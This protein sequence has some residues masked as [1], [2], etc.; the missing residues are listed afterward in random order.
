MPFESFGF[1]IPFPQGVDLAK[2]LAT[3]PQSDGV[4][5]FGCPPSSTAPGTRFSVMKITLPSHLD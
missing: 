3:A 2:A 5:M 4:W 1:L